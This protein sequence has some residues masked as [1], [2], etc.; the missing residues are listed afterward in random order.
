[1]WYFGSLGAIR[2]RQFERLSLR[3]LTLVLIP[4]R[5]CCGDKKYGLAA[6]FG[7]PRLPWFGPVHG[8]ALSLGPGCAK[9]SYLARVLNR[10]VW[11][12]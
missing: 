10:A 4:S 1:M 6:G 12:I 7:C 11:A 2:Y 8:F 5:I 9:L 3:Q